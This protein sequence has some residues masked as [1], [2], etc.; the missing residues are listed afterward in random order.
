MSNSGVEQ[1]GVGE[2]GKVESPSLQ[3]EDLRRAQQ[4]LQELPR[5]GEEK[6]TGESQ[7]G[8][9]GFQRNS[10]PHRLPRSEALEK[11]WNKHRTLLSRSSPGFL[12]LFCWDFICCLFLFLLFETVSAVAP[13]QLTAVSTSWVQEILLPQLPKRMTLG[14]NTMT[15]WGLYPVNTRT[16]TDHTLRQRNLQGLTLPPRLQYSG[17]IMAHCSLNL[18]AS[19]DAPTSA[20]QVAET[21]VPSVPYVI[22]AGLKLLGLNFSLS[23]SK[24]WDYR[25]EPP[26]LAH[27][28]FFKY[29]IIPSSIN[30]QF[31][32][33]YMGLLKVLL[34]MGHLL[35]LALALSVICNCNAIGAT[36]KCDSC[37]PQAPNASGH[38]GAKLRAREE[39]LLPLPYTQWF[40]TTLYLLGG[41]T[42]DVSSCVHPSSL[43][44]DLRGK[45][46]MR[47][48]RHREVKPF[49]QVAQDQKKDLKSG[50]LVPESM[51]FCT[52]LYLCAMTR[53]E[54]SN[55][56]GFQSSH[57]V[58]TLEN[59][60]STQQIINGSSSEITLFLIFKKNHIPSSL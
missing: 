52:E 34:S 6:G 53:C 1:G 58:S 31:L 57:A 59:L 45:V 16:R 26:Y 3:K 42:A 51:S 11:R 43:G 40:L 9:V 29:P 15:C 23:L 25:H 4:W 48:L 21:T 20:S 12:F 54:N 55:N 33:F 8:A 38:A 36:V 39:M 32:L 49:A 24:C 13:S 30:G 19:S 2:W 18:Q 10:P 47:Q 50:S 28:Q 41:V 46:G 35:V 27:F 5:K 37:N 22:Q 56:H 60:I 17:M 7:I 14:T 44:L